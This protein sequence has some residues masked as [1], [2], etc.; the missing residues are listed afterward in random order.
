MYIHKIPGLFIIVILLF[1]T[2]TN[3]SC[4]STVST[5]M[6]VEV[7]D[8]P[9]EVEDVYVESPANINVEVWQENLEVPWSLV[10]LPNGDA[11]ISERPG[12]ILLVRNGQIRN[13]PYAAFEHV[14]H[15][16]GSEK[17]LMGLALHPDFDNQP[18]VY[19]MYT[20][21]NG[22]VFDNR[23][24]RLRHGG[25]KG[26]LDKVMITGIPA[27]SNH[28]GGRIKFGP[29][30]LLYIATGE[31]FERELAQDK[32]SLGGKI[33]RLTP[34]GEIPSDN[35]FG[36]SPIYTLGHRN[37]QGLDWH[38]ETGDLF[39]SEHGPSGEMMLRG[40]DIINIIYKG[41][42]YG[43]PRVV[44]EVNMEQYEDP[45]VMWKN[46]TPPSGMA[47]WNDDLYVATLRSKALIRVSMDHN[48][49][50]YEI[51]R[52]ERWFSP[53]RNSGTYGRLRDALVGPDG[54]LYILTNNR[55]GRGN[56]APN[57][58]RILRISLTN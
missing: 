51:T 29:D 27:G 21:R 40:Y 4:Q 17:G 8:T 1:I 9:Q 24:V 57:D 11:L 32:Q 36:G 3:S 22:G 50:N 37:P 7:G 30:D 14:D 16:Y 56:P 48:N 38:P 2:I 45:V 49:G 15:N 46:A 12:R 28:D 35:P 39:S 47:F 34:E 26:E 33:L 19:V 18:F 25:L 44:G 6:D 55:D 23:V 41:K 52:I 42:N 31:I 43:W 58:D 13:E 20:Y 54:A 5:V 53:S 10:F